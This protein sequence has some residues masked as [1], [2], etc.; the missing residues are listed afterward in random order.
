MRA[1]GPATPVRRFGSINGL[2]GAMAEEQRRLFEEPAP[3]EEE[4]RGEQ[5]AATVVFV[6]G[7]P[8]EYDYLVPDALAGKIEPG[9]RLRVPLGKGDRLVEGY[10]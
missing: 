3:W 6:G 10:R 4:D 5:L 8:G 7:A 9:R 2:V 1:T